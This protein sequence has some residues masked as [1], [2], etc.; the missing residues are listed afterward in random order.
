MKKANMRKTYRKYRGG[1]IQNTASTAGIL[2]RFA[3]L[4]TPAKQPNQPV[5]PKVYGTPNSPTLSFSTAPKQLTPLEQAAKN[6]RNQNERE[7]LANQKVAIKAANNARKAKINQSYRNL[8]RQKKQAA[9]NAYEAS[10]LNSNNPL[11]NT[12]VKQSKNVERK[13]GVQF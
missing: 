13:Y 1:A 7:R 8:Q 9:L 3:T 5:T 6:V 11:S 10:L 2:G 12:M 4:L